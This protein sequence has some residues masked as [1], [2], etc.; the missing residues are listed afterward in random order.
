QRRA[1]AA[2][3]NAMVRASFTALRDPIC[4]GA[5]TTRATRE[6]PVKVKYSGPPGDFMALRQRIDVPS[7][8][9]WQLM[10]LAPRRDFLASFGEP[11]D[12]LGVCLAL[13]TA[14]CLAGALMIRHVEHFL[15]RAKSVF[16][17]DTPITEL[18]RFS[19]AQRRSRQRA[20]VLSLG[21]L[22]PPVIKAAASQDSA[23]EAALRAELAVRTSELAAASERALTSARSRAAF[24][25][26]ISHE[27][28]TPLNGATGM[29]ALLA[30]TPLTRE[31]RSYLE[32]LTASSHQLQLVLD[33]IID[34]CR[35]E[36]G[37]VTLQSAPFHVRGL[38]DQACDEAANTALNK[39]LDF[40][41]DAAG[42]VRDAAGALRPWVV[43][44]DAGRVSKVV[45]TLV[46]NAIKFTDMG[47]VR[48]MARY[49][50][51]NDAAQ[52]PALEVEVRDT[53]PGITPAQLRH[54]FKPFT[55]L[56][57]STS[58]QH[59]GTGLGLAI[60]KRL[61]SLMGGSIEVESDP[62]RGSVFRF[63]LPA[64]LVDAETIPGLLMR[65][66]GSDSDTL[67]TDIQPEAEVNS[68]ADADTAVHSEFQD[69]AGTPQRIDITVLV[70]DD[71]EINLKVACAI[72]AKFGYIVRTANG[73]RDAIAQVSHA[74]AHHEKIDV[75][76]MDVH[77]PGVDGIQATQAIVTQHGGDAP[78][79]IA[80]TADV[81]GHYVQRCLEAGMVDYLTKPLQP[82]ALAQSLLRWVGVGPVAGSLTAVAV[83][84][85]PRQSS[86]LAT[87]ATAGRPLLA[88]STSDDLAMPHGLVDL[89]R[90]N[91]FREFDDSQFTITHEV[92]N[93]LFKEVPVKLS[94]LEQAVANNDVAALISAAHSLRGVSGHVGAVVVQHLCST[95]ERSA[96][97]EGRVP[98]DAG[99]CLVA[100]RSA[101]GRTR[102]LLEN[103]H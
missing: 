24:L 88:G 48:V 47:G 29:S 101:W 1:A 97:A 76:L 56:D 71:N 16:T 91:D 72:L 87:H 61:A 42:S 17:S 80:L 59:G 86:P 52:T 93:L 26:V 50:F 67:T 69:C 51:I 99:A 6:L 38:I 60:C 102:P 30:D 62:G 65:M 20:E 32:A 14:L 41:V 79:I 36:S 75:V 4:V 23:R 11:A 3:G 21:P 35:T 54:I 15:A 44:G 78:P 46:Q 85:A 68:G 28:R 64:P 43:L 83:P 96:I 98:D 77:M 8:P 49:T 22:S 53:G 5:A 95:L 2:S 39:G 37:D 18:Q 92:I 13:M 90:L 34:Y 94:A 10:L 89:D 33:E 31:Q 103:W 63:V 74:L 45:T 25:A 19:V 40:S 58:R 66:D 57:A 100:L 82:W 70:V 9:P 81:S 7:G 55:Q 73:G 12:W 84:T 27:F